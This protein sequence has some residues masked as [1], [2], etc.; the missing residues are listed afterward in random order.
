ME[1][2][3]IGILSHLMP[4]ELLYSPKVSRKIRVEKADTIICSA[5]HI[6]H[7]R[8]LRP[9]QEATTNPMSPRVHG[10]AGLSLPSL[11]SGSLKG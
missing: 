5:S 4:E 8:K 1:I 11:S 3:L 10:R 9:R 7:L 2:C 6:S